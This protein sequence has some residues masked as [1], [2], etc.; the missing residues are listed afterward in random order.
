MAGIKHSPRRPG[1]RSLLA[2]DSRFTTQDVLDVMGTPLARAPLPDDPVL[3]EL[4]LVQ[5]DRESFRC[6][7]GA[8]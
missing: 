2:S 4:D 8:G 6:D 1:R 3:L 7:G 5:C